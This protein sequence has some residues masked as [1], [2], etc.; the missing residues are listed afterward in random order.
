MP[1]R[2]EIQPSGRPIDGKAT[3]RILR[4][5]EKYHWQGQS[6]FQEIALVNSKLLGK[7]RNN[8]EIDQ[9]AV[10]FTMHGVLKNVAATREIISLLAKVADHI[11]SQA[12]G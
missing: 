10:S 4:L 9:D 2:A 3:G 5:E 6:L 7:W 8:I 12:V 1:F 11:E